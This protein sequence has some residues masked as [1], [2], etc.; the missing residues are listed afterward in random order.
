MCAFVSCTNLHHFG[1]WNRHG[2]RSGY[3]QRS[4]LAGQARASA[5]LRPALTSKCPCPDT[6]QTR[7]PE[8][9]M[10]TSQPQGWH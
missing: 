7:C 1:L 9:Q 10:N 6:G 2:H 3:G 4:A 5:R 8:M